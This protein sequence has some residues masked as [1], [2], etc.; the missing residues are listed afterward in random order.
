[1]ITLLLAIAASVFGYVQTRS[2]V[3]RKLSYVDAVHTGAA[4]LVAGAAA[5]LLAMP[6][7]GLLPLIGGGTA[8][9]FGAGVGAGVRAGSRD[10]RQRRLT[11]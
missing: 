10:T 3:R 2:F 6:V 4:P 1:M 9:L 7:A 5:A 8:L 11:A